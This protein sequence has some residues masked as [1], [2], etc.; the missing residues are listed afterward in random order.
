MK[1]SL[2]RQSPATLQPRQQ[3]NA[4][5]YPPDQNF[6][7]GDASGDAYILLSFEPAGFDFIRP[8][9]EVAI[10]TERHGNFLEPP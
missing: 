5:N 3:T 8:V 4:V 2:R 7:R 1:R 10:D 9:D 6:R